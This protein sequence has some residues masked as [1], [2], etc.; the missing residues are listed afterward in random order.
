MPVCTRTRP[1][2]RCARPPTLPSAG[3]SVSAS[4]P[5]DPNP[6]ARS[7]DRCA[8]PPRKVGDIHPDGGVHPQQRADAQR[9]ESAA[10]EFVVG[11]RGVEVAGVPLRGPGPVAFAR[12]VDG[13]DT[14][15]R[16]TGGPGP[17][18]ALP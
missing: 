13:Y 7:V 1:S 9:L 12:H 8:D 3:P 5:I 17:S 10:P 14:P 18:S 11:T 2:S 15:P 16:W 4:G 6:F